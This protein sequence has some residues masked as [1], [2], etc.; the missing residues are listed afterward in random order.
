VRLHLPTG[1]ERSLAAPP[2]PKSAG[3]PPADSASKPDMSL[4]RHPAPQSCGSCHEHHRIDWL[5]RLSFGTSYIPRDEARVHVVCMPTHHPL[6][7]TTAPTSA[8]PE[9]YLRPSLLGRSLVHKRMRLTT[10]STVVESAG[11]VTPFLLGVGWS[12]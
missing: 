7:H 2:L 4:S 12:P 9:H 11:D 8:Y 3:S 10:C 6:F 5:E 1:V